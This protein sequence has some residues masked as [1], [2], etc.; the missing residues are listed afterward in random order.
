MK[1][2]DNSSSAMEEVFLRITHGDPTKGIGSVG[3]VGTTVSTF[4]N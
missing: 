1:F 2:V 4:I 3:G